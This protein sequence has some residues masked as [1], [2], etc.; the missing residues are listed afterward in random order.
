[1][2]A[3]AGERLT[4][5]SLTP[6]VPPLTSQDY[7]ARSSLNLTLTCSSGMQI[8]SSIVSSFAQDLKQIDIQARSR[9]QPQCPFGPCRSGTPELPTPVLP[10]FPAGFAGSSVSCTGSYAVLP[11]SPSIPPRD[12]FL[13]LSYTECVDPPLGVAQQV[14]SG[15]PELLRHA[16]DTLAHWMDG[17]QR[18]LT[19][20]SG[21]TQVQLAPGGCSSDPCLA[22]CSGR[23]NGLLYF[24][25]RGQFRFYYQWLLQP[26][27]GATIP[28][29][30][31]CDKYNCM[32]VTNA[33]IGFVAR[34]SGDVLRAFHALAEPVLTGDGAPFY[35]SGRNSTTAGNPPDFKARREPGEISCAPQKGACAGGGPAHGALVRCVSTSRSAGCRWGLRRLVRRRASL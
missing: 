23:T 9:A 6:R 26:S 11:L 30:C 34:N 7:G 16:A 19:H 31:S 25:P 5:D 24:N 12:W 1:M 4:L 2:Q 10:Q 18:P 35:C 28:Q 29:G 14:R 13:G 3:V 33:S 21:H 15:L 8:T 32:F 17:S 20:P 27:P 22:A